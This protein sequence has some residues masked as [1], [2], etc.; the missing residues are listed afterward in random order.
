MAEGSRYT[1]IEI[2]G[3]MVYRGSALSFHD[4]TDILR[5]EAG[6]KYRFSQVKCVATALDV[7]TSERARYWRHASVA[8]EP[9]DVVS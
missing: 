6:S 8:F 1:D 4:A 5:R 9:N 3:R 7:A 2:E